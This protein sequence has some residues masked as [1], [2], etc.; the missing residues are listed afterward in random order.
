MYSLEEVLRLSEPPLSLPGA[1][2]WRPGHR[3]SRNILQEVPR[4]LAQ[5]S[6]GG[7]KQKKR[8]VVPPWVRG[9]QPE[10]EGHR[11]GAGEGEGAEEICLHE[12]FGTAGKMHTSWERSFVVPKA[13]VKKKE[14]ACLRE[15]SG[16]D[17][18]ESRVGRPLL[19]GL[20]EG[21]GFCSLHPA[22]RLKKACS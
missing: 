20:W 10:P 1:F 21:V 9:Q 5:Y 4:A 3:R 12:I 15:V 14:G 13:R 16:V 19:Q 8:V 2:S 18:E 11:E 22:P 6:G 17:V 7:A